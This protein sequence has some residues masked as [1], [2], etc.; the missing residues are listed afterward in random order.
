MAINLP[1]NIPAGNPKLLDQVR[2]VI[3]RKHYSIRTETAYI[4]WIRRFIL[5]HGKRH[6]RE[7]AEPEVIDFLTHLARDGNVAA[8]TQ[9]QALSG[10]LFLYKDVLKQEIGWIE[11]VERAK[12]PARLPVVLTRDEVRKI[13]AHLQGKY[14]IMAG[15]LSGSGLRLMECV[16][17]RVKNVD[18]AQLRIVVRDGKGA[19][20]RVTMVPVSV[21]SALRRH[22]KKIQLQH[23]EDL[24]AGNGSVFLPF[25]LER[26]YPNAHKEWCWQYVFPSSRLSSDPRAG[27]GEREEASGEGAERGTRFRLSRAYS[28]ERGRPHTGGQAMRSPELRRHHIDEGMLQAA[29]KKAVIAS[30]IARPASCHTFRHSFATHLLESGS[31]IRTVQELLGHSPR[32]IRIWKRN[33]VTFTSC[34]PSRTITFTLDSLKTFRQEYRRTIAAPFLPQGGE[35]L[36]NSYIGRGASIR[37]MQ[38]GERE[39]SKKCIGESATS[40]TGSEAISRGKGCEHDDD[41]HTRVESAGDRGEKPDGLGGAGS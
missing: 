20:D 37:R 32:E 28:S 15:L 39:V 25:A 19:K 31:D 36:S 35:F 22:L 5:Y 9:N 30:K 38:P 27:T 4:D 34:A 2:D 17:L 16:R 6:P 12:R 41:L 1:T 13:F 29:V 18:L 24:E 3:R 26:K 40:K 8:A 14:R 23:E 7:M 11:G 33:I 21:A 10:L